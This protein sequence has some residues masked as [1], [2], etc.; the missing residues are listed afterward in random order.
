MELIE[1][2]NGILILVLDPSKEY[3]VLAVPNRSV[4]SVALVTKP[5]LALP[6]VSFAFPLNG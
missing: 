2:E 6:L 4:V 3:A 5:L 1:L